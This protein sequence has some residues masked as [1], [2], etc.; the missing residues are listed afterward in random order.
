MKIVSGAS[1]GIQF[2]QHHIMTFQ[3]EKRKSKKL[4][5]YLKK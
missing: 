2:F 3:K 1:G 4:E 5:N